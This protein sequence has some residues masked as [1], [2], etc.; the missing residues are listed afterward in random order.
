[1]IKTKFKIMIQQIIKKLKF[2]ELALVLMAWDLVHILKNQ[3]E[4]RL[5]KGY[6]ITQKWH[7]SNFKNSQARNKSQVSP[8]LSF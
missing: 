7:K 2:K 5:H 1:M 4:I 3:A 6:L 8:A